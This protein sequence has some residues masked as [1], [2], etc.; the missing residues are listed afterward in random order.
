MDGWTDGQIDVGLMDGW[1]GEWIHGW[2][3]GWI[4]RWM[5]GWVDGWMGGWIDRQTEDI[6]I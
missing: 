5:D 1:V 2:M 4:D 6:Y 3:G